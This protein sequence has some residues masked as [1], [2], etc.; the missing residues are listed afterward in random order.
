[1]KKRIDHLLK[2]LSLYLVFVVSLF[3]LASA[4][5]K[6]QTVAESSHFKA[7][8]LYSDV[9]IFIQELQS[10]SSMIRVEKLCIS[11]EG[12][13]VPLLVIGNPVPSSPLDLK[14]DKRA[15]VY[16]TAKILI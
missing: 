8:S 3:S 2:G 5:Q 16:I 13:D 12:R 4:E 10:Q 9:I 7:T 15:V 6:P 1:M 14:Y 11:P